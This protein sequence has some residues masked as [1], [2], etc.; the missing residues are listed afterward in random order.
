MSQSILITG[1]YRNNKNTSCGAHNPINC[2]TFS[3]E[4]R[5]H[6]NKVFEEFKLKESQFKN[7]SV[8]LRDYNGKIEEWREKI[9]PETN[10][11]TVNEMIVRNELIDWFK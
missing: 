1:T 8:T 11:K 10:I 9:F 6:L 7:V 5:K 2:R 3:I 4:E